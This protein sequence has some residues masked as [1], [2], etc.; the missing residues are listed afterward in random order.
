MAKTCL[1]NLH[2]VP[3]PEGININKLGD[4]GVMTHTCNTAQKIQQILCN[5][6]G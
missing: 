5:M 1:E 2:L 6:I 3:S 4:G